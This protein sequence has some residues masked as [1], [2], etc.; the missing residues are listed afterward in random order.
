MK[1]LAVITVAVAVVGSV[2]GAY[3]MNFAWL[4]L[5]SAP[6]G[7]WAV[8]LGTIALVAASLFLGWRLGWF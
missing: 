4:P 6:W 3:G 7:F 8:T 5:A 2:F 1:G